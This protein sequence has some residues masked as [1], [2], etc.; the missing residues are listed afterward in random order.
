MDAA[1]LDVCRQEQLPCVDITG[2]DLPARNN[3]GH[4]GFLK[5]Y[6]GSLLADLNITFIFTEMDVMLLKNPWPYHEHED[7]EQWASGDHRYYP[8]SWNRREPKRDNALAE[9]A[10]LQVS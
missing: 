4:I 2:D 5:F 1:T 9:D 6:T 3:S 8:H 10:D 7:S